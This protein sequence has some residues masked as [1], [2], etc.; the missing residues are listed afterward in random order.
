MEDEPTIKFEVHYQKKR[1]EFSEDNYIKLPEIIEVIKKEFQIQDYENIL[2]YNIDDNQ[3]VIN[4]IIKN[5]LV[6]KM[7][8]SLID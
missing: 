7:M 6:S 5:C 3:N 1:I 4:Q 8:E 2:I